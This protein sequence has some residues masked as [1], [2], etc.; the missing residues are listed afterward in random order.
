[1]MLST[2]DAPR[3][4]EPVASPRSRD[5]ESPL[6]C[7]RSNFGGG[8]CPLTFETTSR[9]NCSFQRPFTATVGRWKSQSRSRHASQSFSGS[10]KRRSSWEHDVCRAERFPRAAS[11]YLRIDKRIPHVTSC[12]HTPCA[13]NR[14]CAIQ[15]G[16]GFGGENTARENVSSSGAGELRCFSQHVGLGA[17]C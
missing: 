10:R 16:G 1:M 9:R 4:K 5:D 2:E 3:I 13:A 12:A 8:C 14:C 6:S 15:H 17:P 7:V 11:G